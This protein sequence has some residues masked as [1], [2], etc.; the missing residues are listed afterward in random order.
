MT[1]GGREAAGS[2]HPRAGFT[3][4]E[5][6]L[7]SALLAIFLGGAFT[8][9]IS[10]I[11]TTETLSELNELAANRELVERKLEWLIGQAQAVTTPAAGATSSV[12]TVSGSQAGLYPAQF[13]LS[14]PILTLSLAG[15][16][17]A[18][19]TNERVRATTFIAEHI[20]NAQS[21][22]TVR[23][24]LDLQSMIYPSRMST[25]TMV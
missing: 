24:T 13:S 21:S 6:L 16:A 9:I 19:V 11:S 23:I 1:G 22:S 17:A 4:I 25:G 15:G 7:Y 10:T 8:F 5:V 14:G 18:A 12:L 3:L 2:R 20:S